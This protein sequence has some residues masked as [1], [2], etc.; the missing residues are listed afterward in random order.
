M[1]GSTSVKNYSRITGYYQD[2]SSWNAAKK[3]ELID[4]HRVRISS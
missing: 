2:V 3:Q 4:R 1:C